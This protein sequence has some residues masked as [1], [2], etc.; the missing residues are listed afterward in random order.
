MSGFVNM[1]LTTYFYFSQ[2]GVAGKSAFFKR[3][4]EATH[5]ATK[6]NEQRIKEE[7]ARRRALKEAKAAEKGFLDEASKQK[8]AE[9]VAAELAEERRKTEES[10]AKIEA[11][12]VKAEKDER[13]AR[14]AALNA[15]WSSPPAK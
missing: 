13:A 3:Q 5:D 7:A 11:D 9:Q 12:R 15:K 6:T 2:T 4:A 8:T 1:W 10:D 14:K